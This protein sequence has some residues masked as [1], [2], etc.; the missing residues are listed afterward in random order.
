MLRPSLHLSSFCRRHRR[1][2][3]IFIVYTHT[4]DTKMT[5]TAIAPSP[6]SAA[7]GYGS[8]IPASVEVMSAILDYYGFDFFF[9]RTLRMIDLSNPYYADSVDDALSQHHNDDLNAFSL[10]NAFRAI[11][12][13]VREDEGFSYEDALEFL[14]EENYVVPVTTAMAYSVD[15]GEA[16][17]EYLSTLVRNRAAR[18]LKQ[19]RRAQAN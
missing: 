2:A 13:E 9:R 14:S 18:L 19:L 10:R 3:A 12:A 1:V 5:A 4:K 17:V 16:D 6:A 15:A 11:V 8:T 7:D